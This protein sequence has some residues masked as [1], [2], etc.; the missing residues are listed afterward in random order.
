MF[1]YIAP[2]ALAA[3][4]VTLLVALFFLCTVRGR[5]DAPKDPR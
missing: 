3:F 1:E 5:R 4:F 2:L